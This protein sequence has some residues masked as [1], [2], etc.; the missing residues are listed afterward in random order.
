MAKRPNILKLATK[1]SLE[2]M[3]YTGITYNDPEYKILEPIVDDDMCSVMMHMR[4]EAN[5]TAED[6]AKRC[7][8][9]ISFV[10]AQLDK[11]VAA[12]V[13]RTRKADGKLCYYYPIWVPGI[14]EGIMGVREQC[15]KYPV[16][17]ECFEN[18]TR[19]RVGMLAPVLASGKQG[20]SMM[21][22]M[23]VNSAVENNSR[24]ASYDEVR[25]LI[26]NAWAISVGACSCRRSRRLMGE[27][28]GH[29]EEDMCIYLNDN[30]I[31]FSNIGEHRLISKEEAYE[32]IRVAEANGLVHEINQTPGF[33]DSTAICNCCGC[34]CY[35]LRLATLFRAKDAIRSNFVARVDK[36]KCVACGK[37]VENCQTNALKLGQ[38]RCSTD[39]H[40]S[41]AYDTD[42]MIPWDKNTYNVDYRTDRSDVMESGTAPCKAVCPLNIPSQGYAKLAGE[43]KYDEAAELIKQYT[44]FPSLC[45]YICDKQCEKVCTR[46]RVDKGVGISEISKFIAAR[47]ISNPHTP[48]M[49]NPRGIPF[50][51]KIA[52]IGSGPAGLSCAYYLKIMGYSVTV[53]EKERALGGSTRFIPDFKLDR[54]ALKAEINALKDMGIEFKTGVEIGKSVTIENLREQGYKAFFLGVG[55][56]K[57][58]KSDI[59][60]MDLPCVMDCVELLKAVSKGGEMPKLGKSVAVIG[61]GHA[62]VDAARTAVRLG[63]KKVTV[64]CSAISGDAA[65]AK[66]EG[67]EFMV[68]CTVKEIKADGKGAIVVCSSK[69]GEVEVPATAVITAEGFAVESLALDGIARKENGCVIVD[70]KTLQTSADCVFAGGAAAGAKG[71]AKAIAAGR[72]ASVSIHRAVHAGQTQDIGRDPHDYKGF[73]TSTM[74]ISAG[75]F[76]RTGRQQAE[77]ASVEE[78][79]KTLKNVS[80]ILTE[81]QVCKEGSRCLGCG[82]AVLDEDLCVGCGICTV[83][84]K[85]GA[86]T[87]EKTM[88]NCGVEYYKTLLVAAGNAPATAARLFNK[89]ILKK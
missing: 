16:L 82:T 85:F 29:L 73:V 83:Q 88:D 34:S 32:I 33:E 68:P 8:K 44:P 87:L 25:T 72:E 28:C 37:C 17:G 31:S 51:E 58:V 70:A 53:F 40:I 18:Y 78:A 19:R 80:G 71:V 57:S 59:A 12:G 45:G 11:L 66:A 43:G 54:K 84:C 77:G 50:P 63:A 5:R 14:M 24:T 26:E 65:Q 60:G 86:I 49:L 13:I 41:D 9:D 21:R 79:K 39:P 62:A 64:I 69:T 1:I 81:E 10:Q 6:I 67:I 2:S 61:G 22:V 42:M 4:L 15:D 52:V 23:P 35:A 74:A 3:T 46:N 7:K 56:G 36:D 20:M 30:A 76:S 47:E 89:K 75:S 55:A 48:S 27:G 38:K